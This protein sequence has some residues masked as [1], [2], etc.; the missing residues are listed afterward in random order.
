MCLLWRGGRRAEE[1]CLTEQTPRGVTKILVFVGVPQWGPGYLFQISCTCRHFSQAF[2]W[3][4]PAREYKVV[5]THLPLRSQCLSKAAC[6]NVCYHGNILVR[7]GNLKKNKRV[8]QD[9]P[10]PSPD[11]VFRQKAELNR[12]CTRFSAVSIDSFD[13]LHSSTVNPIFFYQSETFSV[14]RTSCCRFLS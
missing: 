2:F 7:A 6:Y 12:F 5:F 3:A 10:P 9:P 4:G 11:S 14:V 8:A 1:N 13:G